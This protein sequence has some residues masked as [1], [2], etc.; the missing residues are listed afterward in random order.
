MGVLIGTTITSWAYSTVNLNI[1][2]TNL[3][4]THRTYTC[5]IDVG[6]GTSKERIILIFDEGLE[7]E[8]GFDTGLSNGKVSRVLKFSNSN[9]DHRVSIL[10]LAI[11][12]KL[13]YDK[14]KSNAEISIF[15]DISKSTILN[16][17]IELKELNQTQQDNST[18]V[19]NER[20]EDTITPTENIV[21]DNS[22]D[23]VDNELNLDPAGDIRYSLVIITICSLSIVTLIIMYAK[24]RSKP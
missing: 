14:I 7:T 22:V 11:G 3:D 20:T 13:I 18:P 23:E 5:K 9:T 6:D 24:R 17:N 4:D 2:S 10:T 15:E 1:G 19:Y 12:D 16:R 8:S 21:V